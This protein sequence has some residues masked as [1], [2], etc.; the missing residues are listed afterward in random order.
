[1]VT[2]LRAIAAIAL[3]LLAATPATAGQRDL[4]DTL[5]LIDQTKGLKGLSTKSQIEILEA[6]CKAWAVPA[7]PRGKAN[8]G[9]VHLNGQTERGE[10]PV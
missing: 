5:R 3:V 1:V 10:R 7:F 8:C 6:R 2:V 4:V 9:P